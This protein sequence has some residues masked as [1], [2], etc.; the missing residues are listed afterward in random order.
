VIRPAVFLFLG[1]SS[2]LALDARAA[3]VTF[4]WDYPQSGAAG[5]AFYCGDASRSYKTRAD[6]GLAYNFKRT[7]PEGILTFCA[8]TAYDA[9]ATESTFSN[10]LGVFVRA[11][12]HQVDVLPGF[13]VR[14][15][16]GVT[17]TATGVQVRFTLPFD[18]S[19]LN[20]YGASQ[21]TPDITLV[22]ANSGLVIGSVVVSDDHQGFTY[23]KTGGVLAPDTYA[24]TIADRRD[25][26]ADGFGRALEPNGVMG[27]DYRV[28]FVVQPSDSPVLS[29]DE[30]AR[31]PG[32]TV[33]L[34]A[35][36][37]AAGI[38]VRITKGAAVQDVA[39][40]VRYNPAL[41][42]VDAINLD[43]AVTGRLSLA[44]IDASAGILRVRV[45]GISGLTNASTVLVRFYGRVPADAPYRSQHVLDIQD[46]AFNFG[47]LEGRDD[48]GLHVVAMIGDTSGMQFYSSYGALL[49]Q[50]VVVGADTGFDAF[51][52]TDPTIVGDVNCSGGLDSN[53]ALLIQLK[54]VGE[55]VPEIP[56]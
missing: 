51:P 46:L 52:L 12:T 47:A 49:I 28:S 56:D 17:P 8:V 32:Q 14:A 55:D 23:V 40:T 33:N 5:F 24:L 41:L 30:F 38:P 3:E 50:L 25:S 20:L 16:G 27:S 26:V 13:S 6:V 45:T 4:Q 48:D 9:N 19:S 31:G 42:A 54:V 1:I 36:E 43:K 11:D 29:I 53:D 34:P 2:A 10:E 7:L 21:P 18:P 22:G 37:P 35:S 44:S 39:F 15:D